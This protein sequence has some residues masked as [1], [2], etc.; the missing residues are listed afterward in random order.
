MRVALQA[1]VMKPR[2]LIAVITASEI[3]FGR[4]MV[5][6]L[7]PVKGHTNLPLET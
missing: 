6:I 5:I 2:M 4:Q 7:R 1:L 3:A